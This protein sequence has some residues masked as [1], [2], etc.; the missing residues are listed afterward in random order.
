MLVD[1]V[2]PRG[3]KK[4]ELGTTLWLREIGPSNELR[5][6]FGHRPDRWDEFPPPLS[7]GASSAR[8]T[9]ATGP[10]GCHHS[11]APADSA[12]RSA[13]YGAQPGRSH[14]RA[15]GGATPSLTRKIKLFVGLLNASVA[16][17]PTRADT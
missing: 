2:W 14:W 3:I 16:W 4:E 8:T 10:A 9:R 13:G 17:E 12:L 15:A 11:Q 7:R 1:R 6:W 5:K